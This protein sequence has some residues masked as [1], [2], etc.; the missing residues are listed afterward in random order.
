M[1]RSLFA[2]ATVTAMIALGAPARAADTALALPG[3]PLLAAWT[4]PHGGVPPLDQVRV[5]HF[6]PALQAGMALQ[7]VEELLDGN[8]DAVDKFAVVG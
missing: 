8:L 5:E 3:N 6:A 7:L 2:I 1:L 4:G